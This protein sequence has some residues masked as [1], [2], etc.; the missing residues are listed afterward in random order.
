MLQG[1]FAPLDQFDLT[2]YENAVEFMQ[3][4]AG[5]RKKKTRTKKKNADMVDEKTVFQGRLS[6]S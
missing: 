5:M 4:F 2:D 3:Q 6:C 1:E